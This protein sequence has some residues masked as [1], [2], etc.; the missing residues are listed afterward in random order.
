M[1]VQRVKISIDPICDLLGDFFSTLAHPTRMR[2]FCALQHGPQSVT[3]IADQARI[4]TTNASQQLR[5]M[6]EKGALVSEKSGQSVYYRIADPRFFQAANLIRDALVGQVQR[7]A[8]SKY[9]GF[10]KN[11]NVARPIANVS[12]TFNLQRHATL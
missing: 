11:L 8:R 7:K 2:I 5:M 10:A 4:S 12:R 1:A 3:D 9:A 6:R